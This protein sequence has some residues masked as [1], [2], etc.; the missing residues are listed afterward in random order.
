M[1]FGFTA[2]LRVDAPKLDIGPNHLERHAGLFVFRVA[3]F[4][5]DGALGDRGDPAAR[6]PEVSS[7]LITNMNPR[8]TA[9]LGPHSAPCA[10]LPRERV[11]YKTT[12]TIN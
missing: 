11:G 4:M 2:C 3:F 12:F 1:P 6:P 8:V 9:L 5:G 10:E 7:F